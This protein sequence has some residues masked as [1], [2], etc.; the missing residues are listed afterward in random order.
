MT[1]PQAMPTIPAEAILRERQW[2]TERII[3]AFHEG[4]QA[5]LVLARLGQLPPRLSELVQQREHVV[6]TRCVSRLC[7]GCSRCVRAG[8]VAQSRLLHGQDDF[9]GG[10]VA[11]W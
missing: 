8:A 11:S 3:A 7:R 10:L 2:A 1:A 9:P 6:T 4:G 5:M